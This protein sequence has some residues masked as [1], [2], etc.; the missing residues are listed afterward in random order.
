MAPGFITAQGR[1]SE[2]DKSGFVF[3]GCTVSGVTPA[4]L[5]R[6][7]RPYSRVIFYETDMSGVVV[8]QGWDAWNYKGKE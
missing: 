4:Y 3:K 6:A 1:D 7:W 2:T 8:S 5:G